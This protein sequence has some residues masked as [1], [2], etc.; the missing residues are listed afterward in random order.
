M[1]GLKITIPGTPSPFKAPVLL[2]KPRVHMEQ[3]PD[4]TEYRARIKQT[5]DTMFEG[6]FDCPVEVD[7]EFYMATGHQV[8]AAGMQYVVMSGL[9]PAIVSNVGKIVKSSFSLHYSDPEPRTVIYI[10]PKL[11]GGQQTL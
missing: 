4:V 7:I 11:D 1:K 9:C 2:Y 10:R 5:L 6:K 8:N 3:H